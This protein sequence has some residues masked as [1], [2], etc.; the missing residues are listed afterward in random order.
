[1][2]IAGTER[3]SSGN[4]VDNRFIDIVTGLTNQKGR[5]VP[6]MAGQGSSFHVTLRRRL[7]PHPAPVPRPPR[8]S[9][10]NNLVLFLMS[11]D[12]GNDLGRRFFKR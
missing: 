5:K 9:R 8:A 10:Y 7:S 11:L 12:C 3:G 4:I 6:V 1:M 2:Y